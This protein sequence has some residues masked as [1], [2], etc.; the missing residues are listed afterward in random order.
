MK[1]IIT[2]TV[3]VILAVFGI[4][5]Y[6]K[7]VQLNNAIDVVIE[8]FDTQSLIDE[9]INSA[10]DV[11]IQDWNKAC[12]DLGLADNCLLPAY[13]HERIDTAYKEAQD[14]CVQRYK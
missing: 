12:G 14:R 10:Y 2:I 7:N 9:C 6:A 1:N 8:E 11:Y 4:V 3:I 13:K 5:M